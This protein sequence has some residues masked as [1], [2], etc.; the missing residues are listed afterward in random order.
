MNEFQSQCFH[1]S[2][3]NSITFV[4]SLHGDLMSLVW[5]H[6][7]LSGCTASS[8][9]YL[10]SECVEEQ[11]Q[12]FCPSVDTRVDIDWIADE[13]HISKSLPAKTVLFVC[14]FCF[15]FSNLSHHQRQKQKG[16]DMTLLSFFSNY[17]PL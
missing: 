7:W 4:W 8:R 11:V 2:I 5:G 3:T 1:S 13:F 9:T 10:P 14:L 6:I 16:V 12:K 15:V 17:L